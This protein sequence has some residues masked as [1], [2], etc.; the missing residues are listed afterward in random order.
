MLLII[1]AAKAQ[2]IKFFEKFKYNLADNG[3]IVSDNLNFHGLIHEDMANLSRNVRGLV[4]K[5]NLY[6]EFLK[7]NKEFYTEFLDIGDGIGISRK[8]NNEDGK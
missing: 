8:I 2:Y 1:D 4:T 6:I 5:I 3:V 7:Q